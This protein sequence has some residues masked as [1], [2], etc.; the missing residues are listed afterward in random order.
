MP[1]CLPA[2]HSCLLARRWPYPAWKDA[3]SL[4]C[5][6]HGLVG[7]LPCGTN[8]SDFP[9]PTAFASK[10]CPGWSWSSTAGRFVRTGH[11]ASG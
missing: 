11:T 2:M 3:K 5:D 6:Y 8:P 10:Q 9:S 1:A 7:H 4:S